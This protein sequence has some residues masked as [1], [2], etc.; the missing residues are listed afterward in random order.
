MKLSRRDF[1]KF[2]GAAAASLK[3]G[4]AIAETPAHAPPA[5]VVES[6]L[7]ETAPAKVDVS[8]YIKRDHKKQYLKGLIRLPDIVVHT[9]SEMALVSG[10]GEYRGAPSARYA[11]MDVDFSK[12]YDD[13]TEAFRRL[14]E[15]ISGAT[16]FGVDVGHAGVVEFEALVASIKTSVDAIRYTLHVTGEPI[17]IVS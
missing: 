15:D 9:D 4:H 10:S 6:T 13:T 1:L 16:L 8:I 7:V 11:E 5:V 17:T 14:F 2:M 3:A 12:R